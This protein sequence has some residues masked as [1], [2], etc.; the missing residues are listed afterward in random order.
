MFSKSKS[1]DDFVSDSPSKSKSLSILSKSATITGKIVIED[2]IR[3]DGNVEGD[4]NSSGKVVIGTSGCIKGNIVCKSVEVSG[5]IYGD[6]TASEIIILKSSSY[7]EGQITTRNIEIEAG[8]N[9]FGNC[10]MEE[11]KKEFTYEK[12]K[13]EESLIG[14][15][16]L[17]ES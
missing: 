12:I 15:P 16:D 5:K 7:Y 14:I 17:V 8:A 11:S 3:I 2:D 6:V 1:K 10:K 13:R 9:F 4:I